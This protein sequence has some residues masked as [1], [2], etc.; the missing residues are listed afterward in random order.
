M[1]T[2]R[3]SPAAA[4]S[5]EP[6]LAV[7]YVKDGNIELRDGPMG[8]I[9]TIL[10]TG[11]V[12]AVAMSDDGAVIAF[13]HRSVVEH[14]ESLLQRLNAAGRDSTNIPQTQWIPP[15]HI[16][17]SPGR[18]G[19]RRQGAFRDPFGHLWFVGDRS[20]LGW[21]SGSHQ[22]RLSPRSLM[23]AGRPHARQRAG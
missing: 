5:N 18:G 15:G 1:S 23:M 21:F 6:R 14:A 9:Q 13:L 20:P 12:I 8:Q 22:F 19:V 10:N 4:P 17:Y 16:A 7:A 2:P 11:V 3:P